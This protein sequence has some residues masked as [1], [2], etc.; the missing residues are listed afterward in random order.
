MAIAEFSTGR[1]I[2]SRFPA[3]KAIRHNERDSALRPLDSYFS[4]PALAIG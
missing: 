4:H 1:L 2:A 3:S